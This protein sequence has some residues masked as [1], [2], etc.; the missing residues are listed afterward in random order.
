MTFRGS[1]PALTSPLPSLSFPDFKTGLTEAPSSDCPR[2]TRGC[3]GR[4]PGRT[5]GCTGAH[6]SPGTSR[7]APG[8]SPPCP[9]TQGSKRPGAAP[10]PLPACGHLTAAP[11]LRS[12]FSFPPTYFSA[13]SFVRGAA[14]RPG[15]MKT[16]GTAVSEGPKRGAPGKHRASRRPGEPQ[17]TSAGTPPLSSA[18]EQG[19]ME[20]SFPAPTLPG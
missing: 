5:P 15:R 3:H 18:R 8:C 7:P 10:A 4:T 11:R 12:L 20:G 19:L 13:P 9:R 2:R 6:P 17:D 16:C 14:T 1:S